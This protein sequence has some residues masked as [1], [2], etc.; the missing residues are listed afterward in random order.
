MV[1][2]YGLYRR[3]IRIFEC[4]ALSAHRLIAHL[5]LGWISFSHYFQ[6]SKHWGTT[7]TIIM[8]NVD[9]MKKICAFKNEKNSWIYILQQDNGYRHVLWLRYVFCNQG[10]SGFGT[11]S[12]WALEVQGF[13]ERKNRSVLFNMNQNEYSPNDGR[14]KL[15]IRNDLFTVLVFGRTNVKGGKYTGHGNN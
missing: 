14:I 2:R 13:A 15:D 9:V 12:N 3:S 8:D 7:P 6:F 10:L 5:M 4:S 11:R 1:V